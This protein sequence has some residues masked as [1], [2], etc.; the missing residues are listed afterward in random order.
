MRPPEEYTFAMSIAFI[1]LKLVL[2][3]IV[4]LFFWLDDVALAIERVRLRVLE[5]GHNIPEEVI[6]RRYKNGT[7]NFFSSFMQVVDFWLFINNTKDVSTFIAKGY[8]GKPAIVFDLNT[9][10]IIKEQANG[11]NS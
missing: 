9:W 7:I 11:T 5:G 8:L 1:I 3:Y 10:S 6:R 4:L 2:F